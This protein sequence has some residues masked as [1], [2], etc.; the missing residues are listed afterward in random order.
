MGF[1]FCCHPMHMIFNCQPLGFIILSRTRQSSFRSQI[2]SAKLWTMLHVGYDHKSV[3][4]SWQWG[5][6]FSKLDCRHFY[7]AIAVLAFSLNIPF[8]PKLTC[9][10][11]NMAGTLCSCL[12]PDSLAVGTIRHPHEAEDKKREC[13]SKGCKGCIHIIDALAIASPKKHQLSVPSLLQ[14]LK[15]RVSPWTWKRPTP[16]DSK[17]KQLWPIASLYFLSPSTSTNINR[18]WGLNVEAKATSGALNR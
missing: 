17:F 4:A 10:Y 11:W 3:L 8:I 9:R 16:S 12:L 1:P 15:G 6:L 18:E 13:K 5:L 2:T 14:P 7:P